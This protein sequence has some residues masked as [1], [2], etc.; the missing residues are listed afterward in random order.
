MGEF[1][2][3]L[4]DVRFF[5]YHGVFEHERNHGNEYIVNLSVKYTPH[6]DNSA[7]SDSIENTISY[8]D[9]FNIVKDE[10]AIPR[11]LL[12][13]VASSIAFKVKDRFPFSSKVECKITKS[14][15]PIPSFLGSA[16]VTF[17]I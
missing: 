6:D 16:S 10:M 1:Q 3:R 14:T 13:T 12:E 9:L 11:S 2:I 4:E 7:L 15:P 5:S 17:T 8:V